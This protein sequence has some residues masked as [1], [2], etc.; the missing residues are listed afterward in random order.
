MRNV[1]VAKVYNL[2]DS[3]GNKLQLEL[4]LLKNRDGEICISNA[5][6][7]WRWRFIGK[8]IPMPVRSRT[9]FNGFPE[10]IMFDWLKGN[11]WYPHT[12]V[13][14]AS[15]YAKVY[16][17]PNA[18][19][20]SKG[21]ED[22]NKAYVIPIHVKVAGEIAFRDAIRDICNDGRKMTAICMYRYVHPC[23]LEDANLAVNAI[24]FD[25]QQ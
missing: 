1:K 22:A 25:G 20:P 16:E 13:D 10:A 8:K 6:A 14:M 19:E 24:Q 9:W 3:N 4:G 17:L 23:S 2:V 12:C 15:G 21:N 18:E 5:D 7:G 11:G